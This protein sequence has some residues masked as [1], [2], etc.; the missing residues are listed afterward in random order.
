MNNKTGIPLVRAT[1]FSM[2][3]D[4]QAEQFYKQKR[5]I[6]KKNKNLGNIINHFSGVKS[7]PRSLSKPEENHFN[8]I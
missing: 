8:E 6:H 1:R 2:T 7:T 5:S 3:T 4:N